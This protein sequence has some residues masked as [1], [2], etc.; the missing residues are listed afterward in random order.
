LEKGK[1]IVTNIIRKREI[2]CD[3]H[4]PEKGKY[5][6]KTLSV[7]G[8][9][10]LRETSSYIVTNIIRK[11]ENTLTPSIKGKTQNGKHLPEKEDTSKH[12]NEK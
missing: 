5:I 4:H 12:N 8:K 2:H 7:K 6:V 9:N 11:R 1:Y 3:K 10:T